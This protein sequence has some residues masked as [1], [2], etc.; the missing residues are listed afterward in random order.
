M[1]KH[2]TAIIRGVLLADVFAR[3]RACFRKP[4]DLLLFLP[5]ALLLALPLESCAPRVAAPVPPPMETVGVASWYGDD[6][7]GRPTSSGERYNMYLLTAASRT[8][9]LGSRV[10]VTRVDN[11]RSVEVKI[12]DRGPFVEGRIIDLSYGA[13]RRLD[14][15]EKGLAL[16]RL[17]VLSTP[18][19]QPVPRP[20]IAALPQKKSRWITVGSF[21]L[22]K[23]AGWMRDNLASHFDS[24]TISRV[25]LG[26]KTYFRV[27]IGPYS[28]TEES[29]R[30]EKT[31][32]SMGLKG[33]VVER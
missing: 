8:L 11:G 27:Q 22:E 6:F 29:D 5:A 16:V 1:K 12:N 23:N 32:E 31:L 33:F 3:C 14:M 7:H 2:R 30:A 9:P 13:A 25:T 17:E 21:S 26:E 18:A 4:P 28:S 24:V 19:D 10:K 20:D 15:I